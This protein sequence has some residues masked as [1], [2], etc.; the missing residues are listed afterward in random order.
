MQVREGVVAFGVESKDCAL[1]RRVTS[2][3]SIKTYNT[4]TAF[5]QPKEP[6]F[7]AKHEIKCVSKEARAI[8][9][10]GSA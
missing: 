9:N 6:D 5:E 4:R 3:K 8:P 10:P 2:Q 1:T 7:P